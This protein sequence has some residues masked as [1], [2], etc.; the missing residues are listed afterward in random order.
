MANQS[1]TLCWTCKNACGGCSW[2]GRDSETHELR[3]EPVKGWKVKKTKI[4]MYS[5]NKHR[6]IKNY[7]T[8]YIVKDC[9]EYNEG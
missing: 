9:P 3:F 4:L 1:E 2:S 6:K 8:S 5:H 7:A